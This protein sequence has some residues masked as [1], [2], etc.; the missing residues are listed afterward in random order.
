MGFDL[1]YNGYQLGFESRRGDPIE[2]FLRLMQIIRELESG[3]YPACEWIDL[4]LSLPLTKRLI[5]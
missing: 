2:R 4:Q 1:C 5:N 3:A